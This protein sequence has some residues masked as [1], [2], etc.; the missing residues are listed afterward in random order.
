MLV[1]D[2]DAA[3]ES[4]DIAF[5]CH[6]CHARYPNATACCPDSV[7]ALHDINQPCEDCAVPEIVDDDTE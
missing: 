2:P 5:V 4:A 1:N 3:P 6:G 7:V